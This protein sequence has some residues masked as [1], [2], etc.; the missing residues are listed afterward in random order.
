MIIIKYLIRYLIK[1][2]IKCLAWFLHTNY[3]SVVYHNVVQISCYVWII[4][5]PGLSHV[6]CRMSCTVVEWSGSDVVH[7]EA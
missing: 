4:R 1:Y 5:S 6:V 3:H 7:V 2:L